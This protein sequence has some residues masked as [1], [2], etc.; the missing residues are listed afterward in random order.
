MNK[1][2]QLF[3]KF[4]WKGTHKVTL[5]SVVKDYENDRFGKY[6]QIFKIGLA[7]TTI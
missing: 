6:G 1:L 7:K 5:V 2:N 4:L 3:F